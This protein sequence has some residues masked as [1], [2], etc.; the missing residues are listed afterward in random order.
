[1]R[2]GVKMGI[3]GD[4]HHPPSIQSRQPPWEHIPKGWKGLWKGATGSKRSLLEKMSRYKEDP[5]VF[6]T[7]HL[8]FGVVER[9][10]VR[11]IPSGNSPW[12]SFQEQEPS[13]SQEGA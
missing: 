4:F 6:S 8:L 2:V 3:W 5:P 10:G 11:K 12:S 7:K 1:M 9:N 13:S